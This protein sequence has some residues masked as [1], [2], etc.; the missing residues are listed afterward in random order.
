MEECLIG[1]VYMNNI[2]NTGKSFYRVV[3][4]KQHSLSQDCF[5]NSYVGVDFGIDKDLTNDLPDNWREFNKKNIPIFLE[6]N[7]NKSK[8]TAGLACGAIHTMSKAINIGDYILSP[9]GTGTYRIAE[10]TSEYFYRHNETRE[11]SL[12]H[13]RQVRWLSNSIKREDMSEKLK[14]SSGSALT[15]CNISQY[16]EEINNLLGGISNNPIT[17]SNPEIEDPSEF[18]L[19]KHLEDFLIA[20]WHQTELS[21]EYDI[22]ND[23]EVTGQQ[24]PTDTGP[25]DILA[26]SKD[27]SELLIIELKKGRA[28]DTVVGQIQRYMGYIKDEIAEDGQSVRG[29]IIAFDDD[30]KIKRALSMTNN[31][32]FYRYR[33]NFN[34]IKI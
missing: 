9:D 22:F 20:N 17:T 7:P 13:C 28:S 21:D 34:L 15:L 18:A 25:I 6:K 29:I 10:V 32:S 2:L 16:G 14:N 3:L 30:I 26:I 5:N 8:V 23:E 24:F 12:K 19:E 33:V 31:I 27:K 1:Y 4:G 11:H